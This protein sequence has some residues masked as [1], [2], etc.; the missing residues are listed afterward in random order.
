MQCRSGL[1]LVGRRVATVARVFP[2]ESNRF[3]SR[4]ALR[5]PGSAVGRD[6]KY[7]AGPSRGFFFLLGRMNYC[8]VEMFPVSRRAVGFVRS[9]PE[10]NPVILVIAGFFLCPAAVGRDLCPHFAHT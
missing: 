6:E 4:S 5:S 7:R 2:L 3:S 8:G 9:P 1:T 10:T